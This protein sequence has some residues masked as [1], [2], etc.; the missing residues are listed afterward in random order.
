MPSISPNK[1]LNDSKAGVANKLLQLPVARVKT[2][3]KSSPDLGNVSSEAYFLITKATECFVQY[4]AQEAHKNS[5]GCDEVDY[6][7]LSNIVLT[8]DSLEFLEE[9]IPQKIK[10]KEY[11]KL[12][13]YNPD[14][15][16]KTP[17]KQ[18]RPD[19]IVIDDD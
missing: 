8:D 1:S 13:G 12:T 5:K 11:W 2:I 7:H 6:K 19:A 15:Q 4:L 3:M 10:V 16:R 14:L 17:T 9:I 18:T